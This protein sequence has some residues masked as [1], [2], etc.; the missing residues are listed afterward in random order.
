M[1]GQGAFMQLMKVNAMLMQKLTPGKDGGDI[2]IDFLSPKRNQKPLKDMIAD[3]PPAAGTM[4]QALHPPKGNSAE[5]PPSVQQDVIKKKKKTK[6]KRKNR[7]TALVPLAN[8]PAVSEKDKPTTD[9]LGACGGV[10]ESML[11][12]HRAKTAKKK[13]EPKCKPKAAPKKVAACSKKCK[14]KHGKKVL[15]CPKCRYLKNGCSN[16][17]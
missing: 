7:A 4:N 12:R 11:A 16:C 14:P 15:G 8:D 13:L 2:D 17:R 9:A 1:A 5:S 10:L 3:G 6:K